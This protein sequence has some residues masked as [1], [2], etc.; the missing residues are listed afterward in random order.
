MDLYEYQ[1]KQFFASYGIPV[2]AGDAV[3]DVDA[4]PP[5]RVAMDS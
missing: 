4:D 5:S 3:T 1:G 2:S